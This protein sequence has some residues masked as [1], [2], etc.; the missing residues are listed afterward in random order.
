MARR[1]YRLLVQRFIV[2][3]RF[4]RTA[5]EDHVLASLRPRIA[6][7]RIAIEHIRD[8]CLDGQQSRTKADDL[9]RLADH[10]TSQ[11]KST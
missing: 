8:L 7:E 2:E 10:S 5:V 3:G 9:Q 4:R 11:R 6:H 1:S